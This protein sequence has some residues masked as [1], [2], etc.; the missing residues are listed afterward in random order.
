MEGNGIYSEKKLYKYADIVVLQTKI[1]ED[2]FHENIEC[3]SVVIPNYIK[4]F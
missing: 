1:V 2:W 4:P 3:K